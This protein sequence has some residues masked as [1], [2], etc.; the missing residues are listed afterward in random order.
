M[1]KNKRVYEFVLLSSLLEINNIVNKKKKKKMSSKRA[2]PSTRAV[3]IEKSMAMRYAYQ[4]GGIK[5]KDLQKMFKGYSKAVIYK[6]CKK[7]LAGELN[8]DKRIN[9]GIGRP[10]KLCRVD[11]RNVAKA[12]PHLRETVGSYTSK[13]VQVETG[14]KHVSN[15]TVRRAMNK[16]GYRYLRSRKKGVLSPDDI[17]ARYKYCKEK[18]RN[19]VTQDFW[20]YGVSMYLDGTGFAYKRNPLDQ[21]FAPK[22]REWRKPN[23][24]LDYQCTTKGQKEGTKQARFMVAISYDRGVVM[25]EQYTSMTGEICAK[26]M[27][28][29]L[30]QAFALSINPDDKRFVQD[31][32]PCQNSAAVRD[33][34]EGLGA[35]L[36]KIPAR[37]ADLNPIENLFNLAGVAIEED[38]KK[39][40]ITKQTFEEFSA[41]VKNI[42][43]NFDRETINGLIGNM[44]KRIKA[45]IKRKGQR[46]KY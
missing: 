20:S 10:S 8:V 7:P 35:E 42:L 6:H 23:E 38:T 25:C 13:R 17:K 41:R 32:D 3:P 37:S 11:H 27:D 9:S 43:L 18:V 15:R 1:P 21:A 39:K 16:A 4:V 40:N 22:A 19:N 30:P 5:G 14:L 29:C 2:K 28:S 44:E 12:V 46:T 33:I 45:V 34:L 36:V 24:G 31:G 26:M